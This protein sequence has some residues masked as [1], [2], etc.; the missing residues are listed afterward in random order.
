LGV[1]PRTYRS[2]HRE[3]RARETRQRVLEAATRCFEQWGYAATTVGAVAADAGVA[4]PTVEARF[5]SKARLLKAAIDVAIVGDDLEVPVLERPWAE[6]AEMTATARE[7]LILVASV[8]APAQARSAG[9]VLA[10][11]EGAATNPDLATVAD[12]MVAQRR[13]TA[14]WIVSAVASRAPLR[15]EV[16]LAID[17]LWTLMDPA[18]F[19]RLVRWLGWSLEEYQDWFGRTAERLLVSDPHASTTPDRPD[20]GP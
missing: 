9:L 8:L 10:A 7:L 13:G 15:D 20:G 12:E 16:S 1:V 19:Q 5:G 2:D 3:A 6:Q 11:F 17:S 4:V 18:L 14:T